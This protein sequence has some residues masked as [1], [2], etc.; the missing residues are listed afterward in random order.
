MAALLVALVALGSC[1]SA[2]AACA[3]Q[4]LGTGG[5]LPFAN[6]TCHTP[7]GGS[8]VTGSDGTFS[9]PNC[10]GQP[11]LVDIWARQ[12]LST[13]AVPAHSAITL[14]PRPIPGF[15]ATDWKFEGWAVEAQTGNVPGTQIAFLAHPSAYRPPTGDRVFLTSTANAHAGPGWTQGYWQAADAVR[16]SASPNPLIN[17]SNPALLSTAF[18]GRMVV[19]D[20]RLL[21]L[22]GMASGTANGVSLLENKN[23]ADPSHPADWVPAEGNGTILIDWTGAPTTAHEDYR[24]HHFDKGYN[25]NGKTL[26]N[27]L[28]VIPDG[29]AEMTEPLLT[30]EE[31]HE[32]P[33]ELM[34]DQQSVAPWLNH[35]NLRAGNLRTSPQP[36]SAACEQLCSTTS[37]CRAWVFAAG[38]NICFLKNDNFCVN[39]A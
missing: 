25:C 16:A 30:D 4:V 5:P 6:V 28:F 22:I 19:A 11:C 32:V 14:Q 15:P 9:L 35:T 31:R 2:W 17:R 38:R 27:W 34:R 23:L 8:A 10:Q 33:T 12:Y 21:M 18:T 1:R 3:G 26:H 13:A 29:V 24:F 7:D 20:G 36:S 39:P 37:A